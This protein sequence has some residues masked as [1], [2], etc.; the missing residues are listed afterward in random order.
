MGSL[1]LSIQHGTSSSR[2]SSLWF[3]SGD[4][5]DVWERQD[6]QVQLGTF[7]SRVNNLIMTYKEHITPK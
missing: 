7:N 6:V 5:Q 4:Q 2:R 3:K 1:G